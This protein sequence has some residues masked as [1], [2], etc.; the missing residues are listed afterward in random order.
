MGTSEK[1]FMFTDLLDDILFHVFEQLDLQVLLLVRRTS[2]KFRQ[3]TDEYIKN[4]KYLLRLP[5]DLIYT[6]E[7]IGKLEGHIHSALQLLGKLPDDCLFPINCNIFYSTIERD[8]KISPPLEALIAIKK[9]RVRIS[10]NILFDIEYD[11]RYFDQGEEEEGD[12]IV[13]SYMHRLEEIFD[14]LSNIESLKID[15]EEQS[16]EFLSEDWSEHIF[17]KIN[18]LVDQDDSQ[19]KSLSICKMDLDSSDLI[20]CLDRIQQLSSFSMSQV[21]MFHPDEDLSDL[22]KD[23]SDV[24]LD[25]PLCELKLSDIWIYD[26]VFTRPPFTRSILELLPF[27]TPEFLSKLETLDLSDNKE[28]FCNLHLIDYG[29]IDVPLLSMDFYRHLTNLKKLKLANNDINRECIEKINPFIDSIRTLSIVDLSSNKIPKQI[30][31]FMKDM[32]PERLTLIS[33]NNTEL[34]QE[35]L[36]TLTPEDDGLTP[37]DDGL[38]PDDDGLT[39]DDDGLTPDDDGLTPEDD[40]LTPED[41][42]SDND[43]LY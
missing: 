33:V 24:L 10:L 18:E 20:S 41:D 29:D 4:R 9:S 22:G 25:T 40:G 42:G 13:N 21:N 14:I 2:K 19:L 36:A 16:T 37:E 34:E 30:I 38:T 8:V 5:P 39:P 23:F 1:K 43:S 3:S 12:V 35:L 26:G 27:L 11:R 32:L 31:E 6:D 15:L 7:N 28:S 17:D